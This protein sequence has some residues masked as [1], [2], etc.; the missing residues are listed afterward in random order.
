MSLALDVPAPVHRPD[1]LAWLRRELAP[2]PGREAMVLRLVVTVVLVTISSMSLQVP[3]TALSAF[4]VFFVTK[5]NRVLT[6]LT[7]ILMILG[8]TLALAASLVLYRFTF[9]HPELRIPLMVLM[10]FTGM[11][12]SRVFVLGPLGFAIGFI[13]AVTQ[14]VAESAPNADELVRALLYLWVVIVY[15]IAITVVINQILLP[16]HPWTVLAQ[17]LTRRLDAATAALQRAIDEGTAGGHENAALLELA[18]RGSS[19]LYALLHFTEIKEPQLKRQHTAHVTAILASE[20][21]VNAAAA[22]EMRTRQAL[23]HDDLFCAEALLAE[24]ARLR[25]A[26]QTNDFT[27]LPASPTEATPT[28]SELREFQSAVA[29]LRDGSIGK[30]SGGASPAAAKAKKSLFT[31]DAFTNPAHTRFAFKVTLAAMSCYLLYTAL[32]WPGIHTAFITC[33]FIAL[34]NTGATMRKGW[35]RLTGCLLGGLLGFLAIMYLVPQMESIVSLVLLTAAGSLLAGWVAAGSERIAYA[36]LQIGFAFYMCIF[37]GYSPGT[38]FDTIRDRIVGIISRHRGV[39][40]HLPAISG[41]ERAV[42]RPANCA[43]AEF[44]QPRPTPAHPANRRT[45]QCRNKSRR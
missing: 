35:L 31:P 7:G 36:G 1:W 18:S 20:R 11:F 29:S 45:A 17:L 34:E 15:P 8:V 27:T 22:L 42:D 41:R 2:F 40:D 16:A 5:E 30:D 32:D 4:M 14:S 28:I 25:A 33:C 39:L 10:V 3:E 44:A 19:P 13:I 12:L 38:D 9:D 23:S 24:L 21:L 43:R 26:L 6:A 37:Q